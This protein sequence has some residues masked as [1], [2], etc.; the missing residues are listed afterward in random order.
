M[1]RSEQRPGARSSSLQAVHPSSL[2]LAS[3]HAK[4]IT[5]SLVRG[6]VTPGKSGTKKRW[7]QTLFLK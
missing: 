2:L 1:V 4:R 7:V 3:H 5:P 6:L